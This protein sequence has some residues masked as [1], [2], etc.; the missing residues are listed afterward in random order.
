MTVSPTAT[1]ASSR[2][3]NGS[4][5]LSAEKSVCRVMHHGAPPS[6]SEEEALTKPCASYCRAPPHITNV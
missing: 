1:P 4:A 6:D 5:E 3:T 2:P